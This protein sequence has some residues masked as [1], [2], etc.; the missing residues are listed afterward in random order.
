LELKLRKCFGGK[1]KAKISYQG[2]VETFED[3]SLVEIH[4]KTGMQVST[5]FKA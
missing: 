1:W 2:V 4:V 5:E 3:P